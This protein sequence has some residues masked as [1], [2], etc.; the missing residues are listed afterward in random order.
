MKRHLY[1]RKK[2]RN[3]RREG[4]RR[5][6]KMRYRRSESMQKGKTPLA[7]NLCITNSSFPKF[8][9]KYMRISQCSIQGIDEDECV[10]DNV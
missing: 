7:S 1:K 2:Y 4:R 8:W 3:D 10:K 9:S 5:R 6:L